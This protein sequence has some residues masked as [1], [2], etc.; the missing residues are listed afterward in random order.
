ML[1]KQSFPCGKIVGLRRPVCVEK[2][3][4][5]H[6]IMWEALVGVLVQAKIQSRA[7]PANDISE[8][9][10]E[11]GTVEGLHGVLGQLLEF[12]VLPVLQ[13]EASKFVGPGA[14]GKSSNRPPVYLLLHRTQAILVKKYSQTFIQAR[15][16]RI[17]VDLAPKDGKRLWD[18]L[19]LDE[20]R[21]I[22]LQNTRVSGRARAN[23]A[24]GRSG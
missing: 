7:S 8:V 22:A 19:H 9:M 21:Y 24:G 16:V 17:A 11:V 5:E 13:V 1:A 4:N 3:A 14:V 2:I 12:G 18:L 20:P 10:F 15:V 23:L 6:R